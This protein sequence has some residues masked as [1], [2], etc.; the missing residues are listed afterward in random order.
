V[1]GVAAIHLLILGFGV[2]F[3]VRCSVVVVVVV[4]V[5]ARCADVLVSSVSWWW[6]VVS[7][8]CVVDVV[9]VVDVVGYFFRRATFP[10]QLRTTY[11]FAPL[12][13]VL[14]RIRVES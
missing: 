4:V 10:T 5:G 9:D 11:F 13:S 2:P 14:T 3:G 7:G 6:V 1:A 12:R 8:G